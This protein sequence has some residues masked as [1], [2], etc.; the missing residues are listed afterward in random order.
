MN[1]EATTIPVEVS[2]EQTSER[3]ER[4]VRPAPDRYRNVLG[5]YKIDRL[6]CCTSCGRCVEVCRYG[7]HQKPEGYA[8]TLR[9]QDHLCIGPECAESDDS[10]IAQCPQKA[11]VMRRNSSTDCMGDPR[12]TSDLILSTW[13]M[14]ATGHAAPRISRTGMAPRAAGSTASASSSK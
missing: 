5:K 11:L 10:C 1:T 9:P 13:H 14:A 3:V 6:A 8:F 2:V 7:V 4:E 12:W